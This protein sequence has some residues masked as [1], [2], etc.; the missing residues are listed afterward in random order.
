MNNYE[1]IYNDLK[2]KYSPEEI[3]DA[4]IFPQKLSP[5]DK[6]DADKDLLAFRYKMLR[7]QTEEKRIYGDLL[8]FKYLME[9]Y[10]NEKIYDD[11]YSFG[12]HLEEYI[13]ILKKTK[14]SLAE[15][16]DIHYT[17]LS[18][19]INNKEEPNIELIYRLEK[20]AANLIPAI[21]WWKLVIKKQEYNIQR[22]NKIRKKERAKVKNSIKF[23]A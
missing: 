19:I 2:K 16:L 13:R 18:R 20:H 15:D 21:Y 1:K 5:E 11:N 12:N 14:K 23:R 22:D 3:A 7:E 4:M 10:I 6:K 9:D 17:R 8:R